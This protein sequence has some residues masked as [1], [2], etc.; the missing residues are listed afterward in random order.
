MRILYVVPEEFDGKRWGGVSSYT[1]SIAQAMAKRGHE[2]RI[3]TPGNSFQ[4]STRYDTTICALPAIVRT[5]F[6]RLILWP[7][8]VCMPHVHAY[9]AWGLSVRWFVKYYW[10]P[11][12]AEMPE[13]GASALFLPFSYRPRIVVRLHRSWYQY[14]C[15]N[16]L[17]VSLQDR[18]INIFEIISAWCAS[19]VSSP[20][21]FM[22]SRY[23]AMS[24]YFALRRA[25]FR[26]IANAVAPWRP[27][28]G[29]R[30]LSYPYVLT[31]GRIEVGKGSLLLAEVFA[32]IAKKIPRVRL[33]YIG[34][35]T[36]MYI[37]GGW[38]SCAQHVKALFHKAGV[39]H[40]VVLLGKIARSA[41]PKY[42]Q[43]SMFCIVPSR[44]H[45]NP[46]LALLEALAM[47]KAVVASSAGGIPEF[48]KHRKNGLIFQEDNA[49]D[50][51]RRLTMLLL[52][53]R[54]L[55]QLSVGSVCPRFTFRTLCSE[56]E[57][58]YVSLIRP[59]H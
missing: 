16:N 12:I 15:D 34:E 51:S 50:L 56:T 37:D 27:I 1:I 32:R 5:R 29:K 18:I 24:A 22:R 4:C 57:L 35:D 58:L 49:Q 38:K 17:P 6:L 13:W 41:L 42:Y 10:I 9:I 44:G 55:N 46:S 2:V 8:R 21:I 45:E 39:P 43:E 7:I 11:D 31:V 48:V 19:A 23:R 40:R 36:N 25:P 47:R 20:T 30:V 26:V 52:N 3:L 53:S 14:L 28:R 54:L 59:L 33:V